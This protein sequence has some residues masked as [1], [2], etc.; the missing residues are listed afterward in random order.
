MQTRQTDTK[1]AFQAA[2]TKPAHPRRQAT[3][4]SAGQ[5]QQP[6]TARTSTAAQATSGT[7][8]GRS[9]RHRHEDRCRDQW[10]HRFHLCLCDR[11]GRKFDALSGC[12]CTSHLHAYRHAPTG[13]M[14][15]THMHAQTTCSY[16]P[17]MTRSLR[18]CSPI[19]TANGLGSYKLQVTMV[20][21]SS[22]GVGFLQW[23]WVLAVTEKQSLKSSHWRAA[24]EEQPVE[25]QQGLLEAHG[26]QCRHSC[27]TR[28]W[29]RLEACWLERRWGRLC[30][31]SEVDTGRDCARGGA[32]A[33]ARGRAMFKAG[34]SV[35]D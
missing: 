4:G 13:C 30:H 3:I 21:G 6:D 26:W 32:F 17:V 35:T 23:C 2:P 20:L 22:S 1:S 28:G 34:G 18:P 14:C 31:E 25:Q 7:R 16:R 8:C 5:M 15:T 27:E 11:S 24:T 33:V 9:N 12:I 19:F 10:R 29:V